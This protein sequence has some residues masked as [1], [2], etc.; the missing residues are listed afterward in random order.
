[1]GKNSEGFGFKMIRQSPAG[2]SKGTA[3]PETVLKENYEPAAAAAPEPAAMR[4]NSN[5]P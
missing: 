1:M 3:K 5:T 4:G 2:T